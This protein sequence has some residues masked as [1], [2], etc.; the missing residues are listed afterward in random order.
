L[1]NGSRLGR[2]NPSSVIEYHMDIRARMSLCT[3]A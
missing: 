1:C 2:L 3:I